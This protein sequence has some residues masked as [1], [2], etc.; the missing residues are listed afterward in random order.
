[1]DNAKD[2]TIFKKR[3]QKLVSFRFRIFVTLRAIVIEI[4]NPNI[5]LSDNPYYPKPKKALFVYI[6]P[7]VYSGV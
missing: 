2:S 4:E 3:K 1:M 7:C 5:G 6:P